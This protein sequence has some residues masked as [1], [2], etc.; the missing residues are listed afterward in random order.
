MARRSATAWSRTIR[1]GSA[2]LALA[3]LL[4][5]VSM[6]LAGLPVARATDETLALHGRDTLGVGLQDV[7]RLSLSDPAPPGGL[8]VS[9][10]SNDDTCVVA[11]TEN[12]VGG[13]AAVVVTIPYRKRS[14]TFVVQS[15]ESPVG[16]Q[17]DVSATATGWN[18]DVL[19]LPMVQPAL[20]IRD[21]RGSYGPFSAN[22]KLFVEAGVPGGSGGLRFVQGISKQLSGPPVVTVCS[23][24]PTLGTIVDVYGDDSGDDG[25]EDEPIYPPFTRTVPGNLQFDAIAGDDNTDIHVTATAAGFVGDDRIAHVRSL[26]VNIHGPEAL[27]A[28]LQD[29][30]G[31]RLSTAAS[32]DIVVT[33]SVA[34]PSDCVVAASNESLGFASLQRTIREGDYRASF[35]V[36][37]V[38]TTAPESPCVVTVDAGVLYGTDTIS[39]DVRDPGVRLRELPSQIAEFAGNAK[40]FVDIGVPDPRG[41]GLRFVQAL[42]KG[43]DPTPNTPLTVTI[44]SDRKEIGTI[45][46]VGGTDNGDDGSEDVLIQP[47]FSRS[48]PGDVAFDPIAGDPDPVRVTAVA[49]GFADIEAAAKDIL[50]EGASLRI[51]GSHELGAYLQDDYTVRLQNAAGHQGGVVTV[52]SITPDFC[53]VAASPNSSGATSINLSVAAGE[54]SVNFV[55]QADEMIDV[56][57]KLEVTTT[58]FSGLGTYEIDIVQPGIEIRALRRNTNQDAKNDPFYVQVGLPSTNCLSLR[59]TQSVRKGHTVPFEVCS[60]DK[61]VGTIVDVVNVDNGDDGCEDDTVV[62]PFSNNVPGDLK[63]DPNAP[64]ATL[65]EVSAAG[66]KTMERSGRVG[67]H[68]GGDS[69]QLSLPARVGSN[70]QEGASLRLSRKADPGGTDVLLESLTPAICLVAAGATSVGSASISV[71]VPADEHSIDFVVAGEIGLDDE[72]CLIKATATGFLGDEDE[73]RIV[74]PGVKIT[75]L[76]RSLGTTSL[77]EEFLVEIGVPRGG[78]VRP[79]QAVR[80]GGTAETVTVCSDDPTVAAIV[81]ADVSGCLAVDIQPGESSATF[82]LQVTGTAGKAKIKAAGGVDSMDMV[83]VTVAA[84]VVNPVGPDLLGKNLQATYAARA[85]HSGGAAITISASPVETCVVS[86]AANAVG[87]G[88]PLA[89]TIPAGDRQVPFTVQALDVGVCTIRISGNDIPTTEIDVEV[90]YSRLRIRYLA[91]MTRIDGRGDLFIVEIGPANPKIEEVLSNRDN[92]RGITR[93]MA[94]RVGAGPLG[95]DVCVDSAFAVVHDAAQAPPLPGSDCVSAV[96]AEGESDTLPLEFQPA[97]DGVAQ[98]T[99]SPSTELDVGAT[100]WDVTIK[101]NG[102]TIRGGQDE[103]GRGLQDE[104][105]AVFDSKPAAGTIVTV[106]VTDGSGNCGVSPSRADVSDPADEVAIPVD[107]GRASVDFWIQGIDLGDCAVSV[108]SNAPAAGEARRVL[109]VVTPGVQIR[110]LH[111]TYSVLDPPDGFRVEIGVPTGSEKRLRFTQIVA[112]GGDIPFKVCSRDTLVGVILGGTSELNCAKS[113]F[114]AET[115]TNE[116]LSFDPGDAGDTDVFAEMDGVDLVLTDPGSRVPV[117]VRAETIRVRRQDDLGAGLKD[118]Y[119]VVIS[120]AV[121]ANA[122]VTLTVATPATCLV[123]E[124][125]AGP[126][127]DV[128]TITIPENRATAAFWVR[129]GMLGVCQITPSIVAEPGYVPEETLI[130]VVYPTLRVRDLDNSM[131]TQA[132]DDRFFVDIGA[133]GP[134]LSHLAEVQDA[135]ADITVEVCSSNPAVGEIVGAGVDGCLSVVVEEGTDRTLEGALAFNPRG[136]D[137]NVDVTIVCASAPGFMAIERSCRAVRVKPVVPAIK[138]PDLGSG[139]QQ[140]YVLRLS[141]AVADATT[142]TVSVAA[143]SAGVCDV[144]PSADDPGVASIPV[145][146]PANR[147]REQ[148]HVLAAPMATGVCR[149]LIDSDPMSGVSNGI[150]E[151]EVVTPAVKIIQLDSSQSSIGPNDEFKVAVGVPG[152][153]RRDLRPEQEARNDGAGVL[154]QVCSSRPL[155]G[156]IVGADTLTGCREDVLVPP[157]ASRSLLDGLFFDP[158]GEDPDTDVT[159][160]TAAAP[161]FEP[162]QL[163]ARQV[164]VSDVSVNIDGTDLGAGLQD[165]Y[166]L[167]LSKAVPTDTDFV[168]TVLPDSLT[169]CSLA[170]DEL[171]AGSGSLTLGVLEGRSRARFYIHAFESVMGLCRLKVETNLSGIPDVYPDIEVVT[172]SVRIIELDSSHSTQGKDDPFYAQSGI[173]NGSLRSFARVQAARADGVGIP[174]DACSSDPGVGT[175]VGAGVDNCKSATIPPGKSRTNDGDLV[176]HPVGP[177]TTTITVSSDAGFMPVDRSS[178]DIQVSA[179]VANVHGPDLGAGLQDQYALVSNKSLAATTNFTITAIDT[180]TCR[181]AANANAASQ[182]S[183]VVTIGA[184]K[185]RV[186]FHLHGVREGTCELDV[187]PGTGSGVVVGTSEVEV[188]TAGLRIRELPSSQS[189]EGKDVAFHVDAGVPSGSLQGLDYQQAARSDVPPGIPV[190]V[191]SSRPLVGR[192]VGEDTYGCLVVTIP[193][194]ESRTG[195]TALFFDPRGQDL[196]TDTTTVTAE[197]A[198]FLTT[199][200]GSRDVRVANIVANVN[201]PDLGRDLQEIYSLVL[202]SAVANDTVFTVAVSDADICLV[203]ADDASTGH[204]SIPVTIKANRSRADFWVQGLLEGT[205]TLTVMPPPTVGVA[206]GTRDIDIVSPALRIVNLDSSRSNTAANDPFNVDVGIPGSRRQNLDR[207]QDVRVGSGGLTF[208]VCSDN[209][210]VGIIVGE[211]PLDGCKQ[212][213]IAERTSRTADGLLVFDP[214][215]NDPNDPTTI[216]SAGG[217]GFTE[218]GAS[219]REVRIASTVTNANGPDEIGANLQES[220]VLVISTP[221]QSDYVFTIESITPDKCLVSAAET[222][223]GTTSTTVTIPKGRSRAD[224]FTHGIEPGTCDLTLTPPGGVG[225]ADG[226]RRLEIVIPGLKLLDLVDSIKTGAPDDKFRVK[227]GIPSDNLKDISREQKVRA[228]TSVTVRVCTNDVN[229]ATVLGTPTGDPEC[230]TASIGAN[231]AKTAE[232]DLKLRA[233]GYGT[234]TIEAEAYAFGFISTDKGSKDVRVSTGSL[235]VDGGREA[236]GA[237]LQDTFTVNINP[238]SPSAGLPL[239]LTSLTPTVCVVAI[240]EATAGSTTLNVNVSKGRSMQKFALQ[241]L[242]E[243]DCAVSISTT[244]PNYAGSTL[245]MPIVQPGLRIRDLDPTTTGASANDGFFI[246]VGVPNDDLK[247]LKYLQTVRPGSGGLL[248]NACSSNTGAAVILGTATADPKCKSAIIPVSD[249]GTPKNALQLDPVFIGSGQAT[250]VVTASAPGHL[251]TDQGSVDVIVAGAA[252]SFIDTNID[253]VGSGLMDTFKVQASATVGA[254]KTVVVTS[255]TPALCKVAVD[256]NTASATSANIVIKAG[257]KTKTFA[258]HGLEAATGP[259]EL[260][261]SHAEFADGF[262][263]FDVVEPGLRLYD[264]KSS[265]AAGAADDGFKVHVGLAKAGLDNLQVTQKVRTG[266]TGLVVTVC[267]SDPTVGTIFSGS[268]ATQCKTP[269]IPA[270]THKTADNAVKFRVVGNGTTVVEVT[271]DGHITTDAGTKE[272]AVSGYGLTVDNAGTDQI[273]AGLQKGG[274]LV[275]RVG[276]TSGAATV[277]VTSLTPTVCVVSTSG[278]LAGGSSINVSIASGATT[279]GAFWVQG[280][281]AALGTCEIAATAAGYSSGSGQVDI[282]RAALRITNLVTSIAYNAANDPFNVEVGIPDGS[283]ATLAATQQV[284]A[285]SAGI[286]VTVTNGNAG[287][288]ALV[289]S[290]IWNTTI[291]GQS[292]S[293]RINPGTTTNGSGALQKLELDPNDS[294]TTTAGTSVSVS[295]PDLISTG[296]ATQSVT[297]IDSNGSCS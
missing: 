128:E 47:G 95:L 57:C 278:L 113:S 151:I 251:T 23:D 207:R 255:L 162:T 264:L 280:L 206:P 144:S 22:D 171:D 13:A 73:V 263:V 249:S 70:L 285:G 283:S 236:V 235:N 25:C 229:I 121:T 7:Y 208:P 194:G 138:G 237:G 173:P 224:F 267:S 51:N 86:L 99:A 141:H 240:N 288:A 137:P 172:P 124:T 252:L 179:A 34:D 253:R 149:L 11:R 231:Q 92:R 155:V 250:T 132:K 136:E 233:V 222:T 259:C 62:G 26:A 68:V 273:G 187:T 195:S 256:E 234:A 90:V 270:G 56:E 160:V 159:I 100:L 182:A 87:D 150:G 244:D 199:D 168:I 66:F 129:G 296:A 135:G 215:G 8:A 188:V 41:R 209:R 262:G 38:A 225:I 21:L 1:L 52:T 76:R 49:P 294:L 175:I 5:A 230:V 81:G 39:I 35:V 219:T 183:I 271:A 105:H 131:S 205:C 82:T 266:S 169:I 202:S 247:N 44:A 221:Q 32:G 50:V 282:V 284:R 290:N 181:V 180:D 216:V 232:G 238:R 157:G 63:F 53:D 93:A 185:S 203:V 60:Q 83:T 84:T 61:N 166:T 74:A 122:T 177:G 29:E 126:F 292:I 108:T 260:K 107:D 265:R 27:G 40:F 174:V 154:V 102:L 3:A 281:D 142:F 114:A 241:G 109:D 167:K 55:V 75:G 164:R 153:H 258:I 220:Y 48:V 210:A 104:F 276:T 275:T 248:V 85:N 43:T 20:R 218:V 161:G 4:A 125:P 170:E 223:A 279:S 293:V 64:G 33:V 103:I 277:Q 111:R 254:D 94:R 217:P 77:D 147:S 17:C 287:A 72:V 261:A 268:T 200:R 198:G 112:A 36:Q 9:I 165:L 226:T 291:T 178:R 245:E 289:G 189:A 10:D 186:T 14:A 286:T 228:G 163:G 211:N 133:I 213:T 89:V 184:G 96:I 272:V 91:S 54:P 106:T 204:S 110:Q 78:S 30:Y 123:A 118:E 15:V 130:D 297:V 67:I 139:L 148:F 69:I 257:N 295:H 31:A 119:H 120:K 117:A 269:V 143:E 12:E 16:A 116:A 46:D 239:T 19:A 42:R 140:Q 127:V 79:V 2:T 212:A 156:A 146:V 59:R 246:D 115:D 18:S 71:T 214:L 65:V 227:A 45:V 197:S 274:F 24:Q 28:G 145:T 201:G 37:G 196:T 192:I 152:P 6:H 80:Q 242:L 134:R 190:E 191:C 98:V 176:F 88:S 97:D 158:I 58:A 193:A 101:T 243:G